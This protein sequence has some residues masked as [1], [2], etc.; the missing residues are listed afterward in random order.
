MLYICL[1][2]FIVK[3]DK[4]NKTVSY[5]KQITRQHSCHKKMATAGGD[6]VDPVKICLI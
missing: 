5:R 1:H 2:K 3:E 6:V 4:M